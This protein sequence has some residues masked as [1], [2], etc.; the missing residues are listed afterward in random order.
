MIRIPATIFFISILF[1][2]LLILFQKSS[3]KIN[4]FM[5]FYNSESTKAT[6]FSINS[7]IFPVKAESG[8]GNK[9]ALYN[10][11]HKN[12]AEYKE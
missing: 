12:L 4:G 2:Y 8:I 5:Y 11:L 3:T 1:F 6:G 9:I 10:L 7:R